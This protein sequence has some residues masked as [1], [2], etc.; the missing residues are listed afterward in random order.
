MADVVVAFRVRLE[1]A[2]WS[3]GRDG[4]ERERGE[5]IV[6]RLMSACRGLSLHGAIASDVF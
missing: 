2:S 3:R 1:T 4:A 5:G 6:N